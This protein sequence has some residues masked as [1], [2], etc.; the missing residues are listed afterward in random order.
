LPKENSQ[1]SFMESPF[2]CV[3]R[4]W[5]DEYTLWM[6]RYLQLNAQNNSKLL[7][8]KVSLYTNSREFFPFI[9]MVQPFSLTVYNSNPFCHCFS[10]SV[11]FSKDYSIIRPWA[12]PITYTNKSTVLGSRFQARINNVTFDDAVHTS[13]TYHCSIS[14][15]HLSTYHCSRCFFFRFH[16]LACPIKYLLLVPLF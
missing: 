7:K 14:H 9:V 10:L 11:F 12:L 4:R 16:W 2:M 6:R 13:R 5:N 8:G 1:V 15:R 3:E